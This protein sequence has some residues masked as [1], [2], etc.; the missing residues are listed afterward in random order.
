MQDEVWHDN[1]D[2][3]IYS[4]QGE[5]ISMKTIITFCVLMIM[6]PSSYADGRM[7]GEAGFF[8]ASLRLH[9]DW[10]RDSYGQAVW[11]PACVP[12]GWQPYTV[13][14]WIW[15]AE[16]WY[17]ESDEPWGWATYHYGRWDVDPYIGWVWIPGR[18]W[19]PSWVEWRFG[20]G[21]VSW[22]P[23]RPIRR[24]YLYASHRYDDHWSYVRSHDMIGHRIHHH[25][26]SNERRREAH[27]VLSAKRNKKEEAVRDR[28]GPDRHLVG[29][30]TGA[31]PRDERILRD[32][33][34]IS[35]RRDIVP[36]AQEEHRR[37]EIRSGRGG[38]NRGRSGRSDRTD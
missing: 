7:S 17:W 25:L 20:E 22:I 30:R 11:K 12:A 28:R 34:R 35:G 3:L 5:E 37:E 26:L 24:V 36:E 27:A 21:Y 38:D 19:A 10:V 18:E 32:E 6:G 23:L 31:P 1:W 29:H 15:T 2:S 13:G 9:G 16:G 14:R 33:R 4:K 8:H